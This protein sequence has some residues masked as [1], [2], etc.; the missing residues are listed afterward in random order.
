MIYFVA[1]VCV[2]GIASGQLLFKASAMSFEVANNYFDKKGLLI[3]ALALFVYGF[4]TLA[5]VWVLQKLSLGKVY[6]FMALAFLIV[7]IA[8]YFVFHERFTAQYYL[9][10]VLIMVGIYFTVKA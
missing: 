4:T 1:V 3:L 2:V 7:P 9:G 10:V 5:W 8:S 6:P